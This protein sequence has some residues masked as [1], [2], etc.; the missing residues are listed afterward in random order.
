MKIKAIDL[1]IYLVKET[2]QKNSSGIDPTTFLTSKPF[3]GLFVDL[4]LKKV[5]QAST[6][7][8]NTNTAKR[9]ENQ[10]SH[11]LTF[12]WSS[13][14][15]RAGLLLR[16]CCCCGGCSSAPPPVCSI[17][18]P[19]A[20]ISSQLPQSYPFS[21]LSSFLIFFLPRSPTSPSKNRKSI[22]CAPSRHRHPISARMQPQPR[23]LSGSS[24]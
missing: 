14:Q 2:I 7:T 8:K 3:L 16:G 5:G 21:F 24:C 23:T 18:G 11:P 10:T 1:S 9:S 6:S 17:D 20:L 13:R 22:N 15:C 12:F 4:L 19:S